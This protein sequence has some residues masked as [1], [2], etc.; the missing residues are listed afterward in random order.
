ME[1]VDGTRIDDYA[2]G[3]DCAS[4]LAIFLRVCDA[5]SYAHRNLIV[6]RAL[7]PSN[8]LIDGAGLPKL[9]DFGIVEILDGL[10]EGRTVDTLLRPEYAG[11]EL[12]RG[13]T[14]SGA[15]DVY[16]L[17]AVLYRLLTRKSPQA[18]A[19]LTRTGLAAELECIIGKAMRSEPEQR[20]ASVD[21]FGEDVRAYLEHRHVRAHGITPWDFM[22]K[23]LGR[24]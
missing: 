6:H 2:S 18:P 15:S 20:Y 3:L 5:V 1:Y 8:I 19:A 7:K 9:L 12:L 22:R 14:Q 4:M 21:A 13:G 17:G 23:L 11:P 24:E 10:E 16:S